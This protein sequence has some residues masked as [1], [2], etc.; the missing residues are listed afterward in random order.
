MAKLDHDSSRVFWQ[1]FMGGSVYPV[2]EF[3]EETE[4]WIK[5]DHPDID[6]ALDEL[7]TYLD[8]PPEKVAFD[9]LDLV[10]ICA[11]LHLSQKLR[12]M[13]IV[14]QISPGTATKMIS[15]A[16]EHTESDELAKIF[17]ARNIQ[18]ERMRILIRVMSPK[19]IKMVQEIY[20]S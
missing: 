19:R 1:S 4:D 10:R 9:H 12:I 3:I 7:G 8:A 6:S 2:I 16:E 14:D 18:F 13:Q 20:E 5:L 17:L 11:T 15:T